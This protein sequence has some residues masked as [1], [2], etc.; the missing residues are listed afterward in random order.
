VA[1]SAPTCGS[2]AAAELATEL[3]PYLAELNAAQR[4]A[5]VFGVSPD[6][7]GEPGPPLLIIAGAGTGKTKTLTHRVA[8]LLL[9]GADSRRILLLT[10]ARRMAAEM[11]RRVDAICARTL[12]KA[13]LPAAGIEWSGTFHA[14]GA[15]LLRLHAARIGLEPSFSILDRADAED[16]LDLVRTD[17]GFAAARSRFPK[18]GT[19]LAIYSHAVNAQAP[20]ADVVANVFPWCSEFKRELGK[21]CTGYVEAKQAQGALDYD[22]LLLYWSQMMATPQLAASVAQ[23][24]DYVLVDEYQD[25]NALQAAILMGLKPDGRG[26]TVVGD[27]AQSIYSFRSATVRNILDY[28]QRFDPP[29]SALKLEQNYRSGAALL[30]AC[31]R[32][33]GR[34]AEGYRKTLFSLRGDGGKPVIA[35]VPDERAQA[36]LVVDRVLANREAGMALR[37]QAVLMRA[38]HH[39]ALLEMELARRNVPFVKFGGL[40]FIESAHVKDV[41]ALLRWVENPRDQV[42]ALRVLKLVPGIGPV[43]ARSAHAGMQAGTGFSAL[44]D[45][46][47]PPKARAIFSALVATL[48]EL[49][50]SRHWAQDLDRVRRWYDPVLELAYDHVA[51]RRGDLDQL[52]AIARAHASRLSFLTDLALDPPQATGID[53]GPPLKDEDWL[54]LSTIH[55]AKGQEWKAVQILNVVDGCIPSDLAT[56]SAAE[57]EEERR[58]LYVAMTRAQDDLV[59]LQPLRFWIRGQS[60]G[61]DRHVSVAR[62]RFVVDADLDAFEVVAPTTAGVEHSTEGTG[63]AVDLKSIVRGMWS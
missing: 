48:R 8:H 17:L 31:N 9:N 47:A 18:K 59:L 1:S 32:V 13:M 4:A 15:R 53:A 58:L 35:M 6:G 57:I 44:E 5:A 2:G 20:L 51:A 49:A 39:S 22:D 54:V 41:L 16:L 42:A 40:K 28:P 10:F 14:I 3:P 43:A 21:L 33:I 62:S 56:G 29:A 25:T 46:A 30:H 12:G 27:D 37:D 24:F 63:A 7:A 55:S 52:G 50:G 36:E 38:S 23:R 11:T 60:A 26:V 61:G 19:C 45:F 34:A